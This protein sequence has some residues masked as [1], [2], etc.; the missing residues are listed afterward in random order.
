MSALVGRTPSSAR[1]PGRAHGYLA[2]GTPFAGELARLGENLRAPL[3]A[4]YLLAQGP[5][6]R[7]EPVAPAEAVR[8]MLRNIL[9]FAHDD[10]LVQL[11]FRAVF[12]FVTAVP[13]QRLVFIP[14]ARA[15]EMIA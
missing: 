8:A 11:L 15:W 13:V 4:V 14:D 10:E 9:F 12:D 1:P 5:E 3:A 7:I 6:N 2:F